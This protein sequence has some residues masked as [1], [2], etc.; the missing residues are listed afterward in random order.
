[1][2]T[3]TQMRPPRTCVHCGH[4]VGKSYLKIDKESGSD[5]RAQTKY[6]CLKCAPQ[7]FSPPTAPFSI[8]VG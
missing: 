6:Y 2:F 5:P 3:Y 1:M 8:F 4:P 7:Y